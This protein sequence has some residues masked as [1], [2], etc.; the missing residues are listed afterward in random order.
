MSDDFTNIA[1]R[2]WQAAGVADRITL[3][4][5]PAIDSLDRLIS[6][7][8]AGA[9]DFA[10]IDADKE[11]YEAYY[12]RAMVLVRPGGVIAIDNTLWRGRVAD[13]ADRRPKTEAMRAFNAMVHADR[14]VTPVLVPMGDG[15]TLA[16]KRV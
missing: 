3:E 11:A 12:E 9:H 15:V 16:R 14:R 13:P 10:F 4:L 6:A 5:G 8:Q 1:R 2:S 7:G